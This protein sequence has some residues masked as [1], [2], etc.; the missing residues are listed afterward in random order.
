MHPNS[1]KTDQTNGMFVEYGNYLKQT[2]TNN[3]SD[4]YSNEDFT[5]FPM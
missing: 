2:T 5:F 4:L 3:K 1:S